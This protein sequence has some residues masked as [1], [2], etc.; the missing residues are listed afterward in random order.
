MEFRALAAGRN[1]LARDLVIRGHHE[2]DGS[3]LVTRDVI[4][5][6]LS[7]TSWGQ[8][9]GYWLAVRKTPLLR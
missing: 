6:I 3:P 5:L 2:R 9:V 4:A 8:W 1:R 7:Y